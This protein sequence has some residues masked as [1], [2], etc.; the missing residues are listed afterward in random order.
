MDAPHRQES[1][2]GRT[3]PVVHNFIPRIG[4]FSEQLKAQCASAMVGNRLAHAMC[5]VG[6]SLKLGDCAIHVGRHGKPPDLEW[7]NVCEIFQLRQEKCS[8]VDWNSVER[9]RVSRKRRVVELRPLGGG[10]NPPGAFELAFSATL[11]TCLGISN[12]FLSPP[13]PL[14]PPPFSLSFPSR[15]SF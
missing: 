2:S 12:F 8:A 10:E 14:P 5:G 3:W 6:D 15:P 4:I 9:R 1:H 7:N 13:P 11:C